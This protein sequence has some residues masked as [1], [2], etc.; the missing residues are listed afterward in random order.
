VSQIRTGWPEK[1]S[2]TEAKADLCERLA[3]IIRAEAA[4]LGQ[5]GKEQ[6]P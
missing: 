4:K 3:A 1:A 2:H 5:G 6:K